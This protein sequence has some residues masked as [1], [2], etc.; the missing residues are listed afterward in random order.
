MKT[1]NFLVTLRC[2]SKSEKIKSNESRRLLRW[3]WE[4]GIE[5][6]LIRWLHDQSPSRYPI[7]VDDEH[8]FGSGALRHRI[9]YWMGVHSEG[10][11]ELHPIRFRSLRLMI[12]QVLGAE[13]VFL[14]NHLAGIRVGKFQ[15]LLQHNRRK[16]FGSSIGSDV[17]CP[18]PWACRQIWTFHCSTEVLIQPLHQRWDG[19]MDRQR[20]TDHWV[21]NIEEPFWRW[22]WCRAR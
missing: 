8:V 4:G 7:R 1:L 9:K 11:V 17:W 6:E 22:V 19:T 20:E 15:H 10:E 14:Q 13:I 3:T 2:M 21:V 5:W 12:R 18:I 16:L